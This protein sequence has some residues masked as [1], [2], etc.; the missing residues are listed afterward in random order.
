MCLFMN[1]SRATTEGA[2][3][4]EAAIE[5]AIAPMKQ[6]D[7]ASHSPRKA[8]DHATF[9]ALSGLDFEESG[10]AASTIRLRSI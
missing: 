10:S 3:E 7:A 1:R 8:G 5:A 4:I 9:E 6:G 2:G